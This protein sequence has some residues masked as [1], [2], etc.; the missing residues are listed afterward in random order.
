MGLPGPKCVSIAQDGH[1]FV[2]TNDIYYLNPSFV[3]TAIGTAAA[4]N[5]VLATSNLNRAFT[6]ID[7]KNY[8]VM[9]GIPGNSSTIEK[10][11][12]YSY[13]VKAWSY[14]SIS[15]GFIRNA[16]II[17]TITW[18]DLGSYA[19]TW[20]DMSVFVTWDGINGGSS[21]NQVFLGI[22]DKLYYY[23][24][25]A[26]DDTGVPIAAS[27]IT[28]DMDFGSGDADK[29]VK[30]IRLSIGKA[31]SA[32]LS[33]VVSVSTDRGLT[34]KN[35]STLSI[36]AGYVEGFAGGSARGA[37]LRFRFTTSSSVESFRIE[38]LEARIRA[39]G[40]NAV[41]APRS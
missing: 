12:S 19:A 38:E 32:D 30:R 23:S 25:G 40:V 35:F 41:A 2:G 7:M 14:D 3:L 11:W 4:R 22:S 33:F 29:T 10:I 21:G 16:S 8:R 13:L 28:G 18:D 17:S 24:P 6:A 1:Y 20:D 31:V 39:A 36:K 34:W 5:S 37:T 27:F 15:C 26:V 9:F